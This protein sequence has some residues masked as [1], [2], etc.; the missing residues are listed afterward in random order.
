MS[1]EEALSIWDHIEELATRSRRIIFSIIIASLLFAVFPS[2]LGTILNLDFTEY[3]PLVLLI[4]EYIQI[5]LLPEEVNLIAFN[6]LDTFYI[7]V[8][9]SVALGV[10]LT[11]PITANE[12]YRFVAPALYPNEKRSVSWFIITFTLLFTLGALY[13]FYLLLPITFQVL[14]KLVYQ[15]KVIPFFSVKDFFEMVSLGLIGSG[16]FYTF[17]L[18]LYVLVRADLMELDTLKKNRKQVF[19]L[20]LIITAIL[21]DPTPIT[22]FLMTIPFY[23]LFE[24]TIQILTRTTKSKT[25]QTIELGIIK[26]TELLANIDESNIEET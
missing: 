11:L 12:I 5:G 13:A 10:I 22:M 4:I 14:Y 18:I 6:W 23:F 1:E 25:N 17:P 24:A 19:I 21:P 7:Y 26:A 3:R 8:I 20:M 9:V 16:I 15:S 2:D